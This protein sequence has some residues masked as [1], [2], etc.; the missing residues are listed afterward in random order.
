ME[1]VCIRIR[2]TVQGVGFRPFVHHLA[3][4]LGVAGSVRNDGEGVVVDA[5]A[6]AAVLEELA[7]RLV[8]EAPPLARI[9]ATEVAPTSGPRPEVG[10]FRI[11]ASDAGR[12][13]H[14]P[15]AVDTAP[16][17][18]CVRE[19]LD[20]TDRR[21]RYPFITCTDCGPRYTII[22]SVPYDRATT[23]M[24]RFR[25]CR[26]CQAEYDDPSS[27][28]HHA[29]PNACPA[30]GPSLVWREADREPRRGDDALAAAVSSLLGGGI[31]AVKGVGGYHLAVDATDPAAVDRLRARKHRDRKP[32]A[33]LVP[34]L[35]SARFLVELDEAGEQALCSQRRP[36]LLAARREPGPVAPGVA[37]GLPELGVM[38]PPSPLHLLLA[39][40][41]GRPLVLT[42][43]NLSDE[44]IAHD[45]DDAAQRLG[46][47]V[48]GILAHD[49]PIHVRCDDSVV[50]VVAGRVQVLRRSRGHA[51]EP[52][53]LPVPTS[54]PLLAVGAEL[55]STVAVAWGRSVVASHHI[56]D[57]EHLASYRSFLQAIDHLCRLHRVRP[58]AV[59]CDLHPEYLSTKLA[60]DLD[61]EL[62][63]VQH[64]HAH[65][66]SCLVDHG[67][68]DPVVALAFDGLGLGP[69]GTLWGGE[70][71]VADLVDAER[72]GHLTPVALPGG[73][74]AVREPWRMA[75]A[76][77]GAEVADLLAEVDPAAVAAVAA[78]AAGGHSPVTSS[79]GRLF[80]AVSALLG[81]PCRVAYEGEAAVALEAWA[82]TIPHGAAA[83]TELVEAIRWDGRRLDPAP[84]VAAVVEGARRGTDRARLAA[85]FH[86][87]LGRAA[88][89]VACEAARQRGIDA[90]ALTG[91][92][93]QNLR[94]TEV[95]ASAVDAAGLAVLVHRDV[96]PNDGGIS[97][98]QAAVA[99]AR[100][101][102]Q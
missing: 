25:M 90:V 61:L 47:L 9:T 26:A 38:L 5:L 27:R 24:A 68:T 37:P 67:R 41:A 85:A 49:R 44:P 46:P 4:E 32:F 69:D 11:E 33:V 83:L 8:E 55:K 2:G 48:E 7:R 84:L 102:R 13:L 95:V 97:I 70:V 51:P 50:R 3:Q 14:A 12:G 39:A 82:R 71:L 86:E 19:L 40:D 57:L 1:H 62:V 17:E 23:T 30:C 21:Y 64:H 80:D 58:E 59:A 99:A 35:A 34:D 94:L 28:R 98:G 6:P 101:S 91:G 77:A 66:A 42:S 18:A 65:A 75:V 54:R 45:D 89:A 100:L 87:E 96:P 72:V 52:M 22:E 81:G 79:V 92:V 76:W 74:A 43:G 29:Q 56:G 36:I 31:V 16:C 93:F 20:P 78:L 73:A 15:V 53:T 10:T 63:A 60:A 88:A